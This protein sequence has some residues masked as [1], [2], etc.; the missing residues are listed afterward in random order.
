MSVLITRPAP[1]N[2]GTAEA[3]RQRGF[4][5]MLAPVLQFEVLPFRH[6]D[7][8]RYAGIIATSANA[9]RAVRSHPLSA[10]LKDAPVYAVGA[11]T[12]EA[13]GIVGFAN[14]HS[15][16]GD[17]SA[18][19]KLIA[20]VM[21]KRARKAPLLYLAGTDVSGDI[22]AELGRD[23]IAVTTLTVYR[24]IPTGEFSEDVRA[25]FAAQAIEAV[26]HYSARSAAAFVA[27]LRAAGLEIGGLAVP[28][29][30][31]SEPIARVLREAGAT[32][33]VVAGR[34]QETVLLD[35]LERSLRS[36]QP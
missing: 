12:A 5:V 26:L 7:S 19:R 20:D 16:D 15:A 17:V 29:F 33:L 31:L 3:L 32:R 18:L 4:D 2:A 8:V 27:A 24:M 36:R 11:R 1:D 25:A 35:A 34:P 23:G 14:V 10:E 13:A 28:Q 9:L 30:C 22:A 21:P 6:D